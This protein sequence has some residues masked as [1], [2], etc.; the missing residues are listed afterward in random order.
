MLAPI[1]IFIIVLFVYTHIRYHLSPGMDSIIYE[2]ANP[3]RELL[4]NTIHHKQPVKFSTSIGMEVGLEW[5]ALLKANTTQYVN[6][7]LDAVNVSVSKIG[8]ISGNQLILSNQ[9]FIADVGL[10]ETFVLSSYLLQPHMMTRVIHDLVGNYGSGDISVYTHPNTSS[11]H[12]TYLV[13]TSGSANIR[14]CSGKYTNRIC[15]D[16]SVVPMVSRVSFWDNSGNI[17]NEELFAQIET[18]DTTVSPGY[19]IALPAHWWYSMELSPD[20]NVAVFSY[21]S[22]MNELACLPETVRSFL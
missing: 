9:K 12:I 8:D 11:A 5:N 21:R 10:T 3:S 17:A 22:V 14:I 2:L 19:A 7:G 16:S 18:M 4:H 15:H 6:V 20:T 1:C 13:C